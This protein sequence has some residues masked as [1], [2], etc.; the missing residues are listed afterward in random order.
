[1]GHLAAPYQRSNPRGLLHRSCSRKVVHPSED[2]AEA[3]RRVI[4]ASTGDGPL[5]TYRCDFC[6]GWHVG[7][8]ARRWPNPAWGVLDDG[9]RRSSNR[10]RRAQRRRRWVV[11]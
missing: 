8:I 1:M 9:V 11:D 10:R 7:H 3:H 2:I 6:P 4:E 5:H